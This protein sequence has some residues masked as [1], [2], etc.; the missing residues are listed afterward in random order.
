MDSPTAIDL[1]AGAGGAT[2]GLRAAG[3]R[4]L[5]AIEN[6][7]AAAD[8]YRLNHPEVTTRCVDI[9]FAPE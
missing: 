9:P 2:E 3:Y 5:A 7:R 6:D 4:V 8:T 1:F